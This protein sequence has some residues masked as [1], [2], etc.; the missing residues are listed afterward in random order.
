MTTHF[1]Q[2]GEK[3]CIRTIMSFDGAGIYGLT[4]ALWMQWLIQ[5]DA[6]FLN[7]PI[8][9]G[10][11]SM[12]ELFAGTSAGAVNA[13]LF[14]RYSRPRDYI[15]E[16][17][18]FW[19]EPGTWT[20]KHFPD[21]VTSLTGLSAWYGTRDYKD[22]LYAYFGDM[23]MGDLAFPVLVTIYDMSDSE[24]P[25]PRTRTWQPRILTNYPA[26][27]D[28]L[29]C[30]DVS[31]IPV[32][33]I[34]YCATAVPSLRAIERGWADGGFVTAD[35]SVQAILGACVHDSGHH[36]EGP[37]QVMSFSEILRTAIFG[38]ELAI[39][40]KDADHFQPRTTLQDLKVLSIS[41]GG[42]Q[43]WYGDPNYNMGMQW[44][45]LPTNMHDLP[46]GLF[47]PTAYDALSPAV[48]LSVQLSE[49]LLEDGNFF[50]LAPQ[51][52]WIPV[53]MTVYICRIPMWRQYLLHMIEQGVQSPASTQ[54]LQEALEFIADLH[55]R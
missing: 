45:L 19:Y 52:A 9:T 26:Q 1:A 25:D 2:E 30:L 33:E 41:D 18:R 13:M 34:A 44:S 47:P 11:R 37:S 32:A 40:Q 22:T 17:V 16:I 42:P 24:D 35:P 5:N 6:Q 27:I 31:A 15:E 43:T 54:A 7:C 3:S 38:R 23:R 21:S 48:Q 28:S 50:R 46:Q 36:V 29:S 8:E 10:Q 20:N 55:S 14:A 4:Q 51:V 12:T 53:A 39:L 49:G